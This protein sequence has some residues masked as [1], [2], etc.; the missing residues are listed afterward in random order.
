MCLAVIVMLLSIQNNVKNL[1]RIIIS[2]LSDDLFSRACVVDVLSEWNNT[3]PLVRCGTQVTTL[4]NKA[5]Y[6]RKSMDG[7]NCP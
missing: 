7:S 4:A 1:S 5:Y 6:S 3:V 2:W